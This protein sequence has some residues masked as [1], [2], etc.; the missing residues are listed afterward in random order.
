MTKKGSIWRPEE[1]K[2]D[3]KIPRRPNGRK[4]RLKRRQER[5][6]VAKVECGHSPKL[7]S[8][9]P[10]YRSGSWF[11]KSGEWKELRLLAL[12]NCRMCMACGRH[13]PDV[14]LHVDHVLP[15]YKYPQLSLVL[16]NLQILCSECNE[17][18]GAWSEAD[19]R[20]H[21]RNI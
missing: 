21:F 10:D 13:P 8:P 3:K 17:G 16:D 18:K 12:Q 6:A 11:Y 9:H 15:R 1:Q 4:D 5:V 7:G 19:F 2:P 20:H 14:Q